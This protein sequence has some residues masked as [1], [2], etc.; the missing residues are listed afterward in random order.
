MQRI[1]VD[2]AAKVH[3]VLIHCRAKGGNP[4]EILDKA[5]MLRHMGTRREDAS[6]VLENAIQMVRSISPSEG[7][8][9][10]AMDMKNLIVDKLKEIQDGIP[11]Q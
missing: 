2:E 5:R 8:V 10:T 1:E 6:R 9:R 11:T 3:Q 4:V 7:N